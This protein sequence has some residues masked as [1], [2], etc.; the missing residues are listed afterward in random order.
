MKREGG[1]ALGKARLQSQVNNHVQTAEGHKSGG[2]VAQSRQK[3]EY[4]G[5]LPTVHPGDLRTATGASAPVTAGWF[6]LSDSGGAT[7]C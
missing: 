2:K 6:G 5:D 3:G 7:T 1:S 4:T